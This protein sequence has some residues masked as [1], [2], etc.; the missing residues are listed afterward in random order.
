MGYLADVSWHDLCHSHKTSANADQR[1]CRE[2]FDKNYLFLRNGSIIC[3]ICEAEVKDFKDK[4]LSLMKRKQPWLLDAPEQA[5]ED[6]EMGRLLEINDPN[7]HMHSHQDALVIP[8]ESRLGKRLVVDRL[9]SNKKKL[10]D[11]KRRMPPLKKKGLIEQIAYDFHCKG[12]DI[13]DAL[14]QINDGYPNFNE[15]FAD[16]DLFY[17]EY[18]ALLKVEEYDQ[19]EDFVT[20]HKTDELK[21]LKEELGMNFHKY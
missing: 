4:R 18:K 13:E 12:S 10:H 8:P 14:E 17:D 1:N 11:L 20:V 16:S 2:N 6:E 21:K 19:D 9:Y 5:L 15:D 7:V 3:S